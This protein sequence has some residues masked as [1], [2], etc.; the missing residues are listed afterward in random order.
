[1]L[2]SP[3]NLAD[4]QVPPAAALRSDFCALCT[5]RLPLEYPVRAA[6]LYLAVRCCL[7]QFRVTKLSPRPA[8]E[9]DLADLFEESLVGW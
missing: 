8:S 9:S 3:L 4:R 6:S 7:L 5:Q 1:L 2:L